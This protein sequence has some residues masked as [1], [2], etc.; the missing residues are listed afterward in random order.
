MEERFTIHLGKNHN[1]TLSRGGKKNCPDQ[2]GIKFCPSYAHSVALFL[3]FH[4]QSNPL[5]DKT[6]SAV[7][8]W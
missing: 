8:Q 1:S 7:A 2:I 3:G 4:S 5:Q 6:V